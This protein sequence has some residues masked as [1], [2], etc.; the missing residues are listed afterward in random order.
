MRLRLT[1]G[2][3]AA[4][5][6]DYEEGTL[7]FGQRW[8]VRLHLATCPD[9]RAL[10]ATLRALPALVDRALAPEAGFEPMV[11]AALQGALARIAD[12]SG[13]RARPWPATPVPQEALEVLAA[14][15]DLPMRI[16]AATHS[17]IARERA[18]QAHPNHLP[19]AILDQLPPP[20]QWT[21]ERDKDGLARAELLSD[22]LGGQ[23]LSLVHGQPGCRLAPHRHLG[24]ESLLVLEG[25]MED[26][27]VRHGAG[28]WLHHGR[29]SSHGP[30]IMEAGCWFLVREEGS[31]TFPGPG[32]WL[33]HFYAAS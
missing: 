8:L 17:A 24:T 32:G 25:C 21:W 3:V 11:Q 4:L 7:P 9:C 30:K 33:R 27:G 12:P 10:L 28:S 1:C 15:P 2:E 16:L 23:R 22:P 5:L 26:R 31:V 29:G 13:G 20:A 14:G 19:P 18:Q 6:A